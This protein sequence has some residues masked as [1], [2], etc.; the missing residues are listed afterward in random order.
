MY[1]PASVPGNETYKLQW[2]FDIQIDH[3][4]SARQ[5]DLKIINKKKKKKKNLKNCGLCCP[6]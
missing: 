3:L 5:P 2:D 1:N 6:G 4:I